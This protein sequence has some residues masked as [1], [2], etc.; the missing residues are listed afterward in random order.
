MVDGGGGGGGVGVVGVVDVEVVDVDVDGADDV[1]VVA[2]ADCARAVV[3][4]G[5]V[6]LLMA[7]PSFLRRKQIKRV[8]KTVVEEEKV[9]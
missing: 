8:G 3:A 4:D 2:V 9:G 7:V 6:A 5:T 1:D